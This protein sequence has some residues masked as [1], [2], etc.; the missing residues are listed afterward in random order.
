MATRRTKVTLVLTAFAWVLAALTL[1]FNIIGLWGPWH[2]AGFGFVFYLPIPTIAL[3]SSFITSVRE[4]NGKY[5]FK[6][7]LYFFVN[8]A[9]TLFTVVVSAT[10]FW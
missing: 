4:R 1:A 7:I 2:L 6:N 5:V 8:V 3:I 9:I 10:W